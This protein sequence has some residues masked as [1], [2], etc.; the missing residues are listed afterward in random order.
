MRGFQESR[1][2]Q[3]DE[4]VV[5]LQVFAKQHQMVAAACAGLCFPLV[6]IGKR[7][8][9]RGLFPAIVAAALGDVHFAADDGFDVA[10]A[11]FVKE[12]RC[13]KQVAVVGNRHGGHLLAGR[14]IEQLAGF[15]RTIEK[16]EVRVDMQVNKLRLAHG[17]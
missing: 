16:T 11:G 14:F 13:G 3:L 5:A 7:P 12:I 17:I 10:L 6:A 2:D 8:H 9:R 4:I 15:A 1:R